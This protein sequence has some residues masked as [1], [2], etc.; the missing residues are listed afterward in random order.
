MC[1]RLKLFLAIITMTSEKFFHQVLQIKSILRGK[2]Q[3][4]LGEKLET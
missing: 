3:A 1:R 2:V 4:L